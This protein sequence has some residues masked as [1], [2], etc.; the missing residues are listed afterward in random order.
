MESSEFHGYNFYIVI[1]R[2]S[3]SGLKGVLHACQFKA[4][5]YTQCLSKQKSGV[6]S[7]LLIQ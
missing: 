2:E 3:V 7:N 5:K 1:K 6:N 4:S